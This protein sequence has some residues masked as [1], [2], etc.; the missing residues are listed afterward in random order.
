MW[1][2]E[3][4]ISKGDYN[5]VYVPNHPFATKNGY[6]LEHRVVMENHLGRLLNSEEIVHHK[7][8]CKKDNSI[9]N[10][11]VMN[12][13]EYLRYHGFLVGKRMV[14]LKCPTCNKIFIKSR[15][16]T[17]LVIKSKKLNFCS[18]KC[19]SEFN[20]LRKTT[21]MELAISENIVREFNSLDNPEQTAK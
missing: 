1:N 11:Q 19:S 17:S 4:V 8:D 12:R 9:D 3:K 18:H 7:N 2:I 10:L 5:Y 16:K 14:E 6:V 13:I 21:N 15:N 20:S